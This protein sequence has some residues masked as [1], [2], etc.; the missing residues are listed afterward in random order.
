VTVAQIAEA[1]GVTARTFFRYFPT[2]D[3]VV[4]DIWDSTN[5]RLCELVSTA[6]DANSVSD[7]LDQSLARWYASYSDLLLA[8]LKLSRESTSLEM[9]LLRRTAQWENGIAAALQTRFPGLGEEDASVWAA[10]G[11]TLLRLAGD[12][13]TSTSTSFA[14]SSHDIFARFGALV[15][16]EYRVGGAGAM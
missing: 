7:V 9:T 14:E 3:A 16:R 8:L 2:K 12:Q 4:V 11:F 15:R 6:T 10:V 5:A 13:A 1:A